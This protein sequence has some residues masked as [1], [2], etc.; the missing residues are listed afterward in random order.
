MLFKQGDPSTTLCI[1]LSGSVRIVTESAHI[2]E[3]RAPEVVGELAVAGGPSTRTGNVFACGTVQTVEFPLEV[4]RGMLNDMAFSRNLLST[5]AQ[6]LAQSTA[7]RASRYRNEERLIG[8]FDSHL[9][10]VLTAQ[11]LATGEDYGAPRQIEGTIL[12]ADIR[13]FTSKSQTLDPI[14]LAGQL[15][16]YFGEV[17]EVLH[18]SHAFVDKFIGDAVMAFWGLASSSRSDASVAFACA[19]EMCRRASRLSLAGEPI[20]IGVG[21]AS[22]QIFCGNV[23]SA[24]KRQFTVLG[25]AVN[26]AA[27]CE[28][29]CKDLSVGIVVSDRV[30][31]ALAPEQQSRCRA[32]K[33]VA[34]RGIGDIDLYTSSSNGIVR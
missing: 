10:P 17:V 33:S 8:A 22:G 19:E 30:F 26:L 14:E 15:G 5:L 4:A 27:R 20:Q 9:A 6:K 13:S 25:S 29:L 1:L 28:S 24:H 11:L 31:Q 2:S 16:T 7:E 23:G 18:E 3:R 32:H 34:V 21:I 12:F